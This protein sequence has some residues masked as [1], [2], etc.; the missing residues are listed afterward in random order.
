MKRKSPT[1]WLPFSSRLLLRPLPDISQGTGTWVLFHNIT[2]WKTCCRWRFIPMLPELLPLNKRNRRKLYLQFAESMGCN[3][4]KEGEEKRTILRYFIFLD[5]SFRRS[6]RSLTLRRNTFILNR[7]SWG[8]TV[9]KFYYRTEIQFSRLFFDLFCVQNLCYN[10]SKY[11]SVSVVSVDIF[12]KEQFTL[13]FFYSL[14][15]VYI[16][17]RVS[18]IFHLN[19]FLVPVCTRG[20]TYLFCWPRRRGMGLVCTR[21]FS[22]HEFYKFLLFNFLIFLFWKAFISPTTFTHT[23]THEPYPRH[24]TTLSAHKI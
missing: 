17:C 15:Q 19:A 2:I 21:R 11:H 24:L 10:D 20:F 1:P 12:E 3:H 4:C 22:F 7:S 8:E 5:R 6:F 18:F 9:C 23:H 16:V 13:Q 14:L